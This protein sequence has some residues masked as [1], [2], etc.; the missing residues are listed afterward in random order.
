MYIFFSLSFVLRDLGN[1]SVVEIDLETYIATWDDNYRRSPGDGINTRGDYDSPQHRVPMIGFH[2]YSKMRRGCI[3]LSE[4]V[5]MTPS[6]LWNML[7]S[8]HPK[9]EKSKRRETELS[10]IGHIKYSIAIAHH[11]IRQFDNITQGY[12]ETTL[13]RH[14]NNP[15]P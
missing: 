4:T 1:A 15:L 14:M 13:A 8:H 12:K 2:D 5:H 3:L 7:F 9:K 11:V 10:K 6:A